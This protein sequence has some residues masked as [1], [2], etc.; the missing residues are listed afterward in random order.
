MAD[1]F[2]N[3]RTDDAGYA[4]GWLYDRLED[5]FG[6]KNVFR[7]CRSM[8]GGDN[9]TEEIWTAL[10]TSTVLLVVVGRDWLTLM[11]ESGTQRRIDD[12]ADYV[13]REIKEA[14]DRSIRVIP[15][16]LDGAPPLTASDL[17]ADLSTLPI[18]QF[19]EFR[20][21]HEV[22]LDHV[23]R[24][25]RRFLPERQH[26]KPK[27]KKSPAS[28]GVH[29]GGSATIYGPVVGGNVNGDVLGDNR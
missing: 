2:I 3:Y 28:G 7:D 12:P 8:H 24:E 5:S 19:I 25:L 14:L 6:A 26:P 22:D 1:V 11:D 23:V 9:F 29:F 13:R 15:V 18:L 16:L 21:R 17:P 20:S 10:R 27:N 4:A